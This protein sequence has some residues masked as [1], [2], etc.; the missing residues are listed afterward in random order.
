MNEADESLR[1]IESLIAA[2][3]SGGDAPARQLARNLLQVVLDLHG[4]ALARVAAIIAATP[5]GAALL[6][7]LADDPHVGAVLLLH[8]LHPQEPAERVQ[9]AVAKL[10]QEMAA[11]GAR[12]IVLAVDGTSA[13]LLVQ[14]RSAADPV[15]LRQQVESAVVEA[16]P[17]LE[18]LVIEGLDTVG[19][20]ALPALAG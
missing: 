2:L 10:N 6:A 15:W 14:R 16:A 9:H 11:A 17:E 13:R 19:G 7:R 5:D 8:G 3:D 1:R 4:L 20:E 18:E 12:V